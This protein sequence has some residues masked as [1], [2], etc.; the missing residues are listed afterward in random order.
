MSFHQKAYIWARGI[1]D[2]DKWIKLSLFLGLLSFVVSLKASIILCIASG[3]I[4]IIR[5]KTQFNDIDLS[6][7]AERSNDNE[8]LQK[9]TALSE[10]DDDIFNTTNDKQN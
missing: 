9:I 6:Q 8:F 3:M 5:R 2:A 4:A 1:Y 7:V 10:I